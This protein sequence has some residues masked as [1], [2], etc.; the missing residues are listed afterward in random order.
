MQKT[1]VFKINYKNKP[2]HFATV[3]MDNGKCKG[4]FVQ[5]NKKKYK[6]G[7]RLVDTKVILG[8]LAFDL[9]IQDIITLIRDY[10]DC[11]SYKSF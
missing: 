1:K 5:A 11:I 3:I 2:L 4:L 7:W 10:V 9:T 8:V 6:N